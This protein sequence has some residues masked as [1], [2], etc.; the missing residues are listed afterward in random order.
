M[1]NY[2]FTY[3]MQK[4]GKQD[5][6]KLISNILIDGKFEKIKEFNLNDWSFIY[7][8]SV[9]FSTTLKYFGLSKEQINMCLD[10]VIAPGWNCM[11]DIDEMFKIQNKNIVEIEKTL[12][13]EFRENYS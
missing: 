13:K 4:Q 8:F 1:N 12:K 3:L 11:L 10:I 2:Y 7:F 9:Y 5:F 6:N